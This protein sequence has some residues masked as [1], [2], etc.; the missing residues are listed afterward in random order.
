MEA[1]DLLSASTSSLPVIFT[2]AVDDDRVHEETLATGCVAYLRKPLLAH[3]PIG[4]INKAVHGLCVGWRP[5]IRPL[6]DSIWPIR[7]RL[8]GEWC[9][10]GPKLDLNRIH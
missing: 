3:L 1:E 8:C 2:S 6:R 4:A 5:V 10:S 7:L 9:T